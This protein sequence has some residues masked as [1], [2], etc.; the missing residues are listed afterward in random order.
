MSIATRHKGRALCKKPSHPHVSKPHFMKLLGM[1]AVCYLI[2]MPL[3]YS[4]L[5]KTL[6]ENADIGGSEYSNS[7]WLKGMNAE[8]HQVVTEG[9]RTIKSKDDKDASASQTTEGYGPEAIIQAVQKLERR[10]NKVDERSAKAEVAACD[11][12]DSV[13]KVENQVIALKDQ[14][15]DLDNR[16]MEA[17]P[18]LKKENEFLKEE[19]TL[20]RKAAV[21]GGLTIQT[22][23]KV[24]IPKPQKYHGKRDAREI[25]N[26]LW[27]MERY[28]EAMHL[29]RELDIK[30]GSC[31]IRMWEE[32][33]KDFNK[34]LRPHDAAKQEVERRNVQTLAEAIAA[35]ESLVDY[36]DTKKDGRS[37][38]SKGKGGGAKPNDKSSTSNNKFVKKDKAKGSSSSSSSSDMPN[39]RGCYLCGGPHWAR[40]C[41]RRQK[42]SAIIASS[43]E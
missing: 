25:D 4:S 39:N 21:T 11:M 20:L 34:Q 10:V 17:T 7:A 40:D 15:G 27:S 9:D 26:F 38:G 5:A 14:L 41:P 43:G 18:A 30:N 29:R 37:N 23:P 1:E 33:K 28:F 8:L 42:L 32:C 24:E 31:S 13:G 36:K 19:L 22:G 12:T 16:L 6:D 3:Q 2:A 35:T